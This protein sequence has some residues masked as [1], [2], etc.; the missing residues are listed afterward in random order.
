MISW[1]SPIPAV[2]F[3]SWDTT[4]FS[5]ILSLLGT[6]IAIV[7]LVWVSTAH[8]NVVLGPTSP[9]VLGS[10]VMYPKSRWMAVLASSPFSANLLWL[11]SHTNLLLEC[12]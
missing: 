10:P 7:H 8:K 9:F 11:S 3:T 12:A 1:T 2:E 4:Y 6:G 5:P